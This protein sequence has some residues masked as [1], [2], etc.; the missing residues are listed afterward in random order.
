MSQRSHL[1]K[2]HSH[3]KR[4]GR[5]T[6]LGFTL[7]ELLVVIGIIALLVS[8]LLPA[9]NSARKSGQAV[10]CLSNLKQI[11]MATEFYANDAASTYPTAQLQLATGATYELDGITFPQ[12]GTSP[13]W[14]SF[15]AKY[16]TKAKLGT[17]STTADEA[18]QAHKTILWGCPNW[19]GYTSTA[20]GGLNRVQTG[21]GWNLWPTLSAQ[22][23]TNFPPVSERAFISNWAAGRT[24][25]PFG[26]TAT[27]TSTQY[28]G[29]W[30]KRK[31]FARN[32]SQKVLV[33]DSRFWIIESN[34]APA[35][36]SMPAQPNFNN[37][38]TYTSSIPGQTM[39]DVYRHGKYPGAGTVAGTFSTQGGKVSYNFMFGDGHAETL[40][41]M[42]DAY[43]FT[44]GKY[45]G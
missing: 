4:F 31:E 11:F 10:K 17:A 7:V 24:G 15:L 42:R 23:T 1:S 35:D 9:L 34:P 22:S 30:V 18:A 25:V 37:S 33:G 16:V 27:A 6:R 39:V 19:Q 45:P 14:T 3:G 40:T 26:S 32:G 20:L 21:Y 44:R 36:G 43:R 41:D 38:V 28:S 13:Y 2:G 29:N 12:S 5:S 8:I